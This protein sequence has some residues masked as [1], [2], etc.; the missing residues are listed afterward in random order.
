MQSRTIDASPVLRP[1]GLYFETGSRDAE[2]APEPETGV[3]AFVGFATVHDETLRE[4]AGSPAIVLDRWDAHVWEGPIA[5]AAQGYLRHAVRGYFANGGRRCVVFPVAPGGA[6]N[7][8]ALATRLKR[9][10]EFGGALGDRSDI[11]LV[12]VPD[13]ACTLL[14]AAEQVETLAAALRHCEMMA[15]RFALLDA[16]PLRAE[17]LYGA[18]RADWI[19]HWMRLSAELRSSYGALYAPWIGLDPS[20]DTDAPP[21]SNAQEWRA[22]EAPRVVQRVM[23]RAP[24]TLQFVPPSGHVAGMIARLDRRVGVQHAPANEPLDGVLDTAFALDAIEHARLNDASVNCIRSIR[25]RGI[26][27]AGARTLGGRGALAYVSGARVVLGFRRWVGTRMRDLAFEPQTP[28]LWDVIRERLI[29][30][31]LDLRDAGALVGRGAGDAFFVQC[32]AETNPVDER[33]LGAVVAH[34]GLAPSIPAEFIVIRVVRDASG[35]TVS[36]RV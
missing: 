14:D 5:V 10:L 32:D 17:A 16:P 23:Q 29:A 22:L 8:T 4:R 31:C 13:A 18:Q 33:E 21:A 9:A 12:C 35:F 15:D 25:G 28:G 7:G 20:R 36:G 2:P 3:A 19:A 34:V 26:R 6:G 27:V 1:P 30:R 11:D 24:S